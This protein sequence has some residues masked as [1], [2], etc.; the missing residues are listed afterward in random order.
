LERHFQHARTT[1][2]NTA[3]A[4]SDA[5]TLPKKSSA[6]QCNVTARIAGRRGTVVTNSNR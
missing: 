3:H 4:A 2:T 5:F 1:V 6:T